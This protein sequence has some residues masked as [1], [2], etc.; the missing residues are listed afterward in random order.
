MS[1]LL[2]PPASPAWRL[3]VDDEPLP[4]RASRDTHRSPAWRWA[5]TRFPDPTLIYKT[6][7][8]PKEKIVGKTPSPNPKR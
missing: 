4:K 6:A 2:D 5:V 8:D 3:T 1:W 7:C